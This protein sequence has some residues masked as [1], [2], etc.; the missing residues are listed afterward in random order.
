MPETCGCKGVRFCAACKDSERVRKLQIAPENSADKFVSYKC[1]VFSKGRAFRRPKLQYNSTMEEISAS[2]ADLNDRN[3]E[4]DSF[5]L[6]GISLI[7]DFLSEAE[8]KDLICR[9]DNSEWLLSQS[10][11]RKQVCAYI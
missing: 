8:E 10:G 9:I 3:F 6:P 11:R 1:Y 2:Y 7:E 5:D 4:E